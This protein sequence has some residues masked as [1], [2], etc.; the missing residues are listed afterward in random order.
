LIAAA[1]VSTARELAPSNTTVNEE[2]ELLA[3][4]LSR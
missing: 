4:G 3:F 2:K 1:A